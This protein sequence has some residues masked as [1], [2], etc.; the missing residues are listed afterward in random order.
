MKLISKER[1]VVA[2]KFVPDEIKPLKG[3]NLPT[4]LTAI[5]E[6]YEF[7]KPPSVQETQA[8]GAK[9]QNGRLISGN[10]NI[11][12]LGVFNDAISATTTDT[13]DSEAVVKDLYGYLKETF[14][15]REPSAKPVRGFQSELV[16]EFKNN[17][18]R[19]FKAFG[20][21]I[22]LLQRETEAIN[23]IKKQV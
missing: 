16:I 22:A 7:A 5:T 11:A 1:A 18:D 17:P 14:G 8:T 4:L 23:G 6:R 13:N 20:P 10:I 21:L 19:A 12:E 15:I 3:Y 9:F 2:I